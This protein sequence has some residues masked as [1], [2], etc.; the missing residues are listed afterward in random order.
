[1]KD[2]IKG[3]LLNGDFGLLQATALVIFSSVMIS[4]I[5]WV[6]RPGSRKYYKHIS[7]NI[8]DG[9]IK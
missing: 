8:L 9:D 6:Y 3:V 5:F 1:M 4:A 7:E 2:L